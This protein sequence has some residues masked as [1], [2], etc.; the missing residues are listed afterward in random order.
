ML[1]HR[2]CKGCFRKLALLSN[3]N[4]LY[5][6]PLGADCLVAGTELKT[7]FTFTEIFKFR[8]RAARSPEV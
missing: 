4:T 3:A 5:S 6:L 2:K 8:V 7:H 1:G